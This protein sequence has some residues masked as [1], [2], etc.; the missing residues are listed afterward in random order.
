M[1]SI[2]TSNRAEKNLWEYDSDLW[3]KRPDRVQHQV[4]DDSTGTGSITFASVLLQV[5]YSI[6]ARN[7]PVRF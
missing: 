7:K 2:L 1:S 5:L 4:I 6:P 3:S